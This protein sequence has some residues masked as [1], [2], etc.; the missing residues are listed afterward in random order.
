MKSAAEE[1]F[2]S[3]VH[4]HGDNERKSYI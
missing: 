1:R 2:D 3:M 4:L